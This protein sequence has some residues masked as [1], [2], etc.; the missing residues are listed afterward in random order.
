[1]VL[2]SEQLNNVSYRLDSLLAL[3]EK[4]A[5]EAPDAERVKELEGRLNLHQDAAATHKAEVE[6]Q[7]STFQEQIAKLTID[8]KLK[9]RELTGV[10]E[11]LKVAHE[12]AFTAE[13]RLGREQALSRDL[14]AQLNQLRYSGAAHT[15]RAATSTGIAPVSSTST[16]PKSKPA[17]VR[18]ELDDLN[19]DD[20]DFDMPED[21]E[22]PPANDPRVS[23]VTKATVA[24]AAGVTKKASAA[25]A[26]KAP[27][28][29]G[30]IDSLLDDIQSSGT[31][32]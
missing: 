29:W 19:L 20:L 27:Q 11:E 31:K 24:V 3:N 17:P 26:K 10:R 9:D 14:N 23:T 6:I 18:T 5:K 25:P 2:K 7:K 15:A 12:R 13:T 1:L 8:I 32:K 4:N 28:D 22:Q 16:A 21:V 30:D